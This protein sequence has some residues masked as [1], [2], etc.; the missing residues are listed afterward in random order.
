[1]AKGGLV[2]FDASKV[3]D[4]ARGVKLALD[5]DTVLPEAQAGDIAV[6]AGASGAILGLFQ[7]PLEGLVELLEEAFGQGR[8]GGGLEPPG[9]RHGY[10]LG[11]ALGHPFP[12]Q[13]SPRPPNP[14][15]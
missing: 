6:N 10:E 1:M 7:V 5:P 15:C 2:I 14:G 8:G 3:T 4:A 11:A 13:I 12:W 9:R